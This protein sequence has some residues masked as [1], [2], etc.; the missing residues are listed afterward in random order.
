VQQGVIDVQQGAVVAGHIA[1]RRR[2]QPVAVRQSAHA[3]PAQGVVDG[4]RRM[5]G[6]RRQAMGLIAAPGPQADDARHLVV[7]QFPRGTVRTRAAVG[8]APSPWLRWRRSH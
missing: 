1:H 2:G 3:R 6:Q 5:T 4:R 7:S 8:E